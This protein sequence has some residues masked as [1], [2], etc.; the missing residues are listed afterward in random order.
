V[1][2][3]REGETF[4]IEI[5]DDGTSGVQAVDGSGLRGMRERA[6]QYGGSLEAGP[7]LGRGWRVRATFPVEQVPA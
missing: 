3:G 5:T 6:Q 7:A 4:V 2:L 1:R